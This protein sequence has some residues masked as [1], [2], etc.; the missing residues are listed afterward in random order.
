MKKSFCIALITC[1]SLLLI[2][3][4]CKQSQT[5]NYNQSAVV[6]KKVSKESI[7]QTA[8]AITVKVMVRKYNDNLD[9]ANSSSGSGVLIA[10]S[11]N[12]YTVV[13]NAH[14]IGDDNGSYQIQTFD[15]K[16]HDAILKNIKSDRSGQKDLTLLQFQATEKYTP[17]SLEDNKQVT[18]N[19][20][21]FTSGFADGEYELT[22]NSGKIGQ[23]S[24]KPLVGGYQIGFTNSTKQGMSGGALLNDEGKVIGVLGLGAAAILDG[25]YLYAD[26]SHPDAQMLEKLRENSFAVPIAS[27]TAR[28]DLSTTLATTKPNQSTKYQGMVGKI[29]S[30]AEKISVKINSKNNGNGSGVIVA[31][32]GDTYYVVTAGHVVTNKDDYT[33]VTSDGQSYSIAKA[34]IK[35]SQGVDLAIVK[36]TSQESYSTATIADYI[37][38]PDF[39]TSLSDSFIFVS[40]FPGNQREKNLTGGQISETGNQAAEMTKDSFSLTNGNGLLYTNLSLPG[41]SGGAVLDSQGRLIGI[42]T[43]AE[44]EYVEEK[45]GQYA[46][47]ALGY[48]LGIPSKKLLNL[49]KLTDIS[50]TALKEDNSIPLKLTDLEKKSIKEQL[51]NFKVP[52]KNATETDWL[53]YGNQLWRA[54]EGEKAAKKAV[55]AFDRAIAINPQEYRAYY[56]KA[57]ALS[58]QQAI[59]ALKQATKLNPD[60]YAA[61]QQLAF[62][63]SY[64]GESSQALAAYNRAIQ[65]EPKVFTNYVRRGEIL[66]RLKRYQEA[67]ASYNQSLELQPTSE[68]YENRGNINFGLEN[69]Q[70][71]IADYNRAKKLNPEGKSHYINN[72]GIAYNQLKDYKSAVAILSRAIKQS[73]SS[74]DWITTSQLYD[75]RG[76]AYSELKNYQAALAD[77]NQA[78]KL[79]TYTPDPETYLNRALIYYHLKNVQKGDRDLEK[80]IQ[81]LKQELTPNDEPKLRDLAKIF[82]DAGKPEA[83]RKIQR[84][85]PYIKASNPIA[86]GTKL[87]ESKKYREAVKLYTKA[88]AIDPQL[89]VAYTARAAC[90][91]NLKEYQLALKDLNKAIEINP[92]YASAYAYRSST[93]IKLKD[94]RQALS[95]SN[96][97]ISLNPKLALAYLTRGKAYYLLNQQQK[98]KNNWQKSAELYYEHHEPGTE[99]GASLEAKLKKLEQEAQ[100]AQQEN[101]LESYQATKAALKQFQLVYYTEQGGNLLYDSEIRLTGKQKAVEFFTKAI[102]LN[103]KYVEAYLG[104]ARAYKDLKN[105]PKAIADFNK[106]SEINHN[107]W[108]YADLADLYIDLKDYKSALSTYTK[109]IAIYP[110]SDIRIRRAG[111]YLFQLKDY[112]SAIADYTKTSENRPESPD[113]HLGRGQAYFSLKNYKSAIADFTKAIQLF[114][115]YTEAYW[116]RS[117][118]YNTLQDYQSAT[119]DLTKALDICNADKNNFC[120]KFPPSYVQL[121]LDRSVN[122]FSLEQ[123]SQALVDLNKVISIEPKNV[124]AYLVRGSTYSSLEQ[125]SQALVDLNKAISLEPKNADAYL[126]RAKVYYSLK[127]KQ[128]AIENWKTVAKLHKQQGDLPIAIQDS[129]KDA[130]LYQQQGKVKDYQR[131]QQAIE[132]FK[133]FQ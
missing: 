3:T 133:Q 52:G 7:Q 48:S 56:G 123:Y 119:K 73:D 19:Q 107:I 10:Q 45:P 36:F 13:T 50:S 130:Q 101:N 29:D 25:A 40:G 75:N 15:G 58:S 26:G 22:F 39:R 117:I 6:A 94:D 24:Q 121:Y 82:K 84:L 98:A 91:Y 76:D 4:A 49:A 97:A 105:Y 88:I 38:N 93:Y 8:S 12:I 96:Q 42:N 21:V 87:V 20:A 92:K 55:A 116:H 112:K 129:Q 23:V 81:I 63:L 33:V 2:P 9:E 131:V 71:A 89:R 106:A 85:I 47:V 31:H 61:W 77:Y 34:T 5:T 102:A 79:D 72:I 51:F 35:T 62:K 14:V 43:G 17:A 125:Y 108:S 27:L 124:N 80:G 118:V 115:E 11:G 122:Y 90:Y 132:V 103:D 83:E 70:S 67:I 41:M 128:Q 109:A 16:K 60:F 57:S 69:Y 46:E 1:S 68:A 28:N 114:P 74:Q 99:Q 59:D 104:R 30:I 86:Q 126:V 66:Q 120:A 65:L 111:I 110:D 18:P 78:I 113:S 32:E 54:S 64:Y 37:N 53:N 127:D 44:N 100:Q 95:D